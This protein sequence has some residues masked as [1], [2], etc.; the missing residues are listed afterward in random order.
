MYIHLFSTEST[1]SKAL[2]DCLK[3]SI[4]LDEHLFIFGFA[5][6]KFKKK[7]F[8]YDEKIE[9]RVVRLKNPLMITKYI[10]LLNESK[11]IYLHLLSYDPT[12]LFWWCNL[13]LI[14]KSTWIIWGTDIYSYL[15]RNQNI[16]TRLY[17]SLR[18]VIIPQ[19]S[20]ISAFVNQ[21][22]ALVNQLYHT[23]AEFI[24][25][26][27]PYP[28]NFDHLDAVSANDEKRNVINVMIGNSGD[29][30]NCHE[31]M[32]DYLS[33]FKDEPICIY[34]PLSYGGSPKYIQQIINKGKNVFGD[35]F[36]PVVT[37]MNPQEYSHLLSTIDIALMNHPRQ[38]AL[39]NITALLYLGRK[40]YL[41][42]DVTTYHFMQEQNIQVFDIVELKNQTYAEFIRPV[43]NVE[44]NKAAIQKISSNEYFL[45]LWLRLFERH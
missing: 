32:I 23:K 1:Y 14:R 24:K 22:L 4:E 6:I 7:T 12:L 44:V 21:D 31:E 35:K 43:G 33:A 19:F 45:S 28:V 9:N 40:V 2:L 17:E 25:T 16:K 41:R 5:F 39:G 36:M 34:C 10:G 18:K 8:Q 42:S 15:K 11:W 13:K 27:Y 26:M 38:Q 30:T 20:E 37:T 29:S 3:D